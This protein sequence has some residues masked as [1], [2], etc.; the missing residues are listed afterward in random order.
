[1]VVGDLNMQVSL[2]TNAQV[3]TIVNHVMA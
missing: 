1:M 2:D 3:H